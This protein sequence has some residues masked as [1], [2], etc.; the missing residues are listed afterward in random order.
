MDADIEITLEA[1][2]G[3]AESSNFAA[4]AAS[5]VNRLSLGV[6]SFNDEHLTRLGRIHRAAEAKY[7][8][9]LAKKHFRRLTL[10]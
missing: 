1:N 6:Q 4:Y 7:A 2:P 3:S 9:E 10:T 8:I 5:G